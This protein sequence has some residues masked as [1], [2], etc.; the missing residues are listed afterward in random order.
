M[1]LID[2]A[3]FQYGFVTDQTSLVAVQ[4]AE[5]K[6]VSLVNPAEPQQPVHLPGGLMNFRGGGHMYARP[7]MLAAPSRMD[8]C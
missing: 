3:D 6:P 7:M 1:L 4:G 8:A 5:E 2:V